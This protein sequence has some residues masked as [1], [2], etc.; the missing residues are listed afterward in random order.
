M[1]VLVY[2]RIP[3]RGRRPFD[4]VHPGSEGR[5]RPRARCV[6]RIASSLGSTCDRAVAV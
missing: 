3:P 2:R 5:P 4:I 1:F 6:P